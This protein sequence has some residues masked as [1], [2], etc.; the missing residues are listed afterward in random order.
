VGT[1]AVL[2]VLTGSRYKTITNE[3]KLYCQGKY[4]TPPGKI[5]AKLR[6]RAIGQTEVIDVRPADLLPCELNVLRKEIGNL[7]KTEEDVL[8]YAMFP[9]IGRKFLEDRRNNALTPEPLLLKP[10]VENK[11]TLSEFDIALHGEHYHVKVGG[12][13]AR[14]PGQQAYYLWVDGVPEE[15]IVNHGELS[16]ER[17]FLPVKRPKLQPG[18]ITVAMP[19]TVVSV[20]VKLGDQV[21]AGQVLLVMEA[22]KMETEIQ[23]PITGQIAALSCQKGDKVT[24]EQVLMH[25]SS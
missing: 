11:E 1:Q 18:D 16:E 7:A 8:S 19:G 6:K 25:V 15:V 9:D 20:N 10:V 21:I 24:P 23:A 12:V 22:M 17:P 4:G 13:G 5:S 3:V 2:N 14:M